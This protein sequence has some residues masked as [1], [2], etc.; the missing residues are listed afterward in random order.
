MNSYAKFGGA[1]R[2]HFSAICEKPMGEGGTYVPPGRAR[3]NK[4]I[5]THKIYIVGIAIY[6]MGLMF[7]DLMFDE[8]TKKTFGYLEIFDFEIFNFVVLWHYFPWPN[9]PLYPTKFVFCLKTK[10]YSI[11]L[12]SRKNKN[13]KVIFCSNET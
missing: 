11:N 7:D 5:Q 2:R 8:P 3:V 1:A 6:F 12:N 10:W 4:I 13:I 9:L